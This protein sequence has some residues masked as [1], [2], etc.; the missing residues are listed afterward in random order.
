[1][2]PSKIKRI[3]T[4]LYCQKWD[5][6]VT[7]YRDVLQFDGNHETDRQADR[8]KDLGQLHHPF[9]VLMPS[10]VVSEYA[11]KTQG[12]SRTTNFSRSPR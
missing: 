8:L 7:F 1:M 4:I 6:T 2:S 10:P 12:R 5:D 11:G 9:L 3:N